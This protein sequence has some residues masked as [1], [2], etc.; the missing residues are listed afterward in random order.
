MKWLS[1]SHW[2]VESRLQAVRD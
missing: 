1:A 2:L